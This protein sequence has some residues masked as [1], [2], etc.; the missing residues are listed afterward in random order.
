MQN[1]NA[2]SLRALCPWHTNKSLSVVHPNVDSVQHVRSLLQSTIK[3][4]K[5]KLR[6]NGLRNVIN[7][8][9]NQSQELI[10]LTVKQAPDHYFVYIFLSQFIQI[11]SDACG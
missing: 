1:A 11:S 6:L 7:K 8:Q 4:K 10:K 5:S 9:Q 3:Y 2:V